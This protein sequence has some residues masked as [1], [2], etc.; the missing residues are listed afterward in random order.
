MSNYFLNRYF[1]AN[2][3]HLF[4]K[5]RIQINTCSAM[6][7]CYGNLELWRK[8]YSRITAATRCG[9]LFSSCYATAER[10]AFVLLSSSS[11]PFFLHSPIIFLSLLFSY[12][13]YPSIFSEA[14][15]NTFQLYV[16]AQ[17][18]GKHKNKDLLERWKDGR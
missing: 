17:E 13:F 6:Y 11:F 2:Q 3:K 4:S 8:P 7:C 14:S 18:R 16:S 12:P 9:D 15:H 10:R 1:Q 5:A